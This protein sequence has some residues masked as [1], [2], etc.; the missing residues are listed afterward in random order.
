VK[1]WIDIDVK[2]VYN[3]TLIF[4]FLVL[5]LYLYFIFSPRPLNLEQEKS[6]WL[7][8]ST[9][10]LGASQFQI[11]NFCMFAAETVTK[12]GEKKES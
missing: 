11:G 9:R 5:R 8:C 7:S 10:H 1:K 6:Q 2:K 3:F 12:K 4:K